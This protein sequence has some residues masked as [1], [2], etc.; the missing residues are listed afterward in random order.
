MYL[1]ENI[2]W[3]SDAIALRQM[4]LQVL[5]H[6]APKLSAYQAEL[7]QTDYEWIRRP[8]VGMVMV[9]GRTEGSGTPFA[10]GET[11]VSRCV[12]RLNSGETGFGYVLGRNKLQAEL[13][14]LAD[15]HLQTEQQAQWLE[16]MM[17]PLAQAWKQAQAEHSA[18]VAS[19]RVD[20]FTMVRG[21]D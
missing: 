2:V 3:P 19:S 17:K 20:F 7:Q 14:A 13:I 6:Q 10:M 9:H 11:T 18:K 12:L 16:H 8:E 21:E 15:A 4:C 5:A 1:S